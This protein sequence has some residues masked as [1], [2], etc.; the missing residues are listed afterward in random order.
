MAT[1]ILTGVGG[2]VGGDS[3]FFCEA[4]FDIVGIENDMR[5][6]L[7]GPEASTR[8]ELDDLR[9]RPW[10]Y[11]RREGRWLTERDAVAKGA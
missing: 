4:G 9:L 7:R 3:A 2:L 10:I 8:P 11:S 6:R 1:V 5:A